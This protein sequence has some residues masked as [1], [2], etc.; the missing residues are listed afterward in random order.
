M[1]GTGGSNLV[2]LLR[3]N[4]EAEGSTDTGAKSLSV[5][6]YKYKLLHNHGSQSDLFTESKDTRVVDLGFDEC[7]RVEITVTT[8][9]KKRVSNVINRQLRPS[10]YALAPTSRLTP[11]VVA[12]VS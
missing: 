6:C 11:W 2:Q 10:T 9:E 7:S 1:G 5:A 12:F 8:K 4:S 3:I